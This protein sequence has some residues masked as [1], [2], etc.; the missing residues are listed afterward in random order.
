ME[1]RG[2]QKSGLEDVVVVLVRRNQITVLFPQA[3]GSGPKLRD[4]CTVYKN[5]FIT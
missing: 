2:F 3:S 4:S 1:E 5:V